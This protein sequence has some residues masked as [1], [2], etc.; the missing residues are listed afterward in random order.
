MT[1]FFLLLQF[2]FCQQISSASLLC[3]FDRLKFVVC[4]YFIGTF[5]A[6]HTSAILL[7][8]PLCWAASVSLNVGTWKPITLI[9]VLIYRYDTDLLQLPYSSDIIASSWIV[10]IPYTA[11]SRTETMGCQDV[12]AS[13]E[14]GLQSLKVTVM[15]PYAAAEQW[16]RLD[17]IAPQ[18]WQFLT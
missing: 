13:R 10:I 1:D 7:K 3:Q 14:F 17:V 16:Y 2:A 6:F 8:T 5:S 15:F 11:C 4:T 9:V 12:F 18:H